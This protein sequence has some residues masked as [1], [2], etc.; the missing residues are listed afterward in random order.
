MDNT[1]LFA[2]CITDGELNKMSE[3]QKSI[4]L[5]ILSDEREDHIKMRPNNS[6]LDMTARTN[7]FK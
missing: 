1:L 3:E 7:R 4:I 6:L 5:R 2:Y